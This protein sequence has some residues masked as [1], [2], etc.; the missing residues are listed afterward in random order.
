MM[1]IPA[2][3][4]INL[5]LRVT[6]RRPDGLHLIDSVA[7]FADL[8]DMI[9]ITPSDDDRFTLSGP[10]AAMLDK[11]DDNLVTKARDHFRQETGW[12]QPVTIN[13]EKHIPV[14]A[15]IGGGSA[16][17]AATLQGLNAISGHRLDDENLQR[18]GLG[19][20]ADVPVCL[21]SVEA[22]AFRMQG[23]GEILTALTLPSEFA[24]TPGLVLINQGIGV[25]TADVFRTRARQEHF[26]DPPRYP[27]EL[28]VASFQSLLN[29]GND[30]FEPA[31]AVTPLLASGAE[32]IRAFAE[33]SGALHHGM[34]GSGATFFALFDSI[35]KAEESVRHNPPPCWHWAGGLFQ[36][37]AGK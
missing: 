2:A 17:A 20:G 34:S 37:Q 13:L 36:Q 21:K 14:A 33:Q 10:M 16:D 27:E 28:D 3:A 6:G 5:N 22:M 35:T 19:L 25:S 24:P 26:A 11:D 12:D 31:C 1:V 30:L 18:L 8:K 23:V 15:G 32:R 7:V 29:E 4:K 9:T